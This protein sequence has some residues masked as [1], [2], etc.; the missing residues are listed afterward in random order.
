MLSL[1]VC[2]LLKEDWK[3]HLAQDEPYAATPG[4]DKIILFDGNDN[5]LRLPHGIQEGDDTKHRASTAAT[6]AHLKYGPVGMMDPSLA[7]GQPRSYGA[8]MAKFTTDHPSSASGT[9]GKSAV[10]SYNRSGDSATFSSCSPDTP[11]TASYLKR[12]FNRHNDEAAAKG[13]RSRTPPRSKTP[14]NRHRARSV[15]LSPSTDRKKAAKPNT[16]PRTKHTMEMLGE[17]HQAGGHKDRKRNGTF[18]TRIVTP[19][20]QGVTWTDTR[21]DGTIK[22]RYGTPGY[23]GLARS[24]MD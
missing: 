6:A 12:L 2:K 11:R 8:S 7:S 18:Q 17:M 13:S 14:P 20:Y 19:G 1:H 15:S 4:G 3:I 23:Q 9:T 22:T 24:N 21:R 5:A 16:D 10:S